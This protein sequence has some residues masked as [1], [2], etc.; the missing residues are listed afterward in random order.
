MPCDQLRT[1]KI[2]LSVA[3]LAVFK[4]GLEAA[5]YTVGEYGSA[6]MITKDNAL[7]GS[8]ESDTGKM[9]YPGIVSKAAIQ[10]RQ[11]EMQRAYSQ[12]VVQTQAVRF[13]WTVKEGKSRAGNVQYEVQRRS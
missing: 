9:T 12:G 3:D 6:I 8:F 2:D 13:G 4:A 7:Y 1:T 11:N 5:G 10:D